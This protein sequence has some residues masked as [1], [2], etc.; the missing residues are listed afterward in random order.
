MKGVMTAVT[1][2]VLTHLK[3]VVFIYNDVANEVSL[4]CDSNDVKNFTT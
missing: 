3:R 4:M 2:A 1:I